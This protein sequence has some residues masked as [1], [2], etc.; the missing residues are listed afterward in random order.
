MFFPLLSPFYLYHLVTLS[1]CLPIPSF[2]P[3][4]NPFFFFQCD[5]MMSPSKIKAINLQVIFKG[6]DQQIFLST[7]SLISFPSV[8]YWCF[9]LPNPCSFHCKESSILTS[10]I[11]AAPENCFWPAEWNG[12]NSLLI[13]CQHPTFGTCHNNVNKFRTTWWVMKTMWSNLSHHS[14]QQAAASADIILDQ[15]APL[16]PA[17]LPADCKHMCKPR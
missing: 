14:N 7:F 10:R 3:P 17:D 12:N 9:T 6:R 13:P 4:T 11:W 2:F 1:F 15:S 16:L 8:V 5:L